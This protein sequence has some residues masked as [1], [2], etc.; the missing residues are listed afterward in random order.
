MLNNVAWTM[1]L[2]IDTTV[3]ILTVVAS[4]CSYYAH[5]YVVFRLFGHATVYEPM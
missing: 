5:L 4:C 3:V 2:I 1:S